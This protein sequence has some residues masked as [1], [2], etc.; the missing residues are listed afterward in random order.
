MQLLKFK[1]TITHLDLVI[2][3]AAYHPG[4]EK[5]STV[6]TDDLDLGYYTNVR[7]PIVLFQ[8]VLPT[9]H[10]KASK[11]IVLSSGAGTIGQKHRSNGGGG[12]G[13]TKVSYVRVDSSLKVILRGREV[14]RP[15][16]RSMKWFG[17][18][19][20][21]GLYLEIFEDYSG[22]VHYTAVPRETP[23]IGGW[24]R[25]WLTYVTY[26][27]LWGLG[28]WSHRWIPADSDTMI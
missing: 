14:I 15:L 20:G 24:G 5:F 19:S 10:P 9:L 18:I 25:R 11:F 3:N 13:I 27:I 23:P 21:S 6:S 8:A 17:T 26:G 4:F 7:G 12:Y 1:Y 22:C 2:A 28:N 16:G